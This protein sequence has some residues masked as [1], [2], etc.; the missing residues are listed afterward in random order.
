MKIRGNAAQSTSLILLFEA[1]QV[2]EKAVVIY[3][4]YESLYIFLFIK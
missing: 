2:V 3:N 4:F 1:S